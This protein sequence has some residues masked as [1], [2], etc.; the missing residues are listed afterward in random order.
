MEERRHYARL[1]SH[2]QM[3][4]TVLGT[5][6]RAASQTRDAGGGGVCFFTDQK[7][8]RGTMMEIVIEFPERTLTFTGTVVWSGEVL[9]RDEG[10]DCPPFQTGVKF[11]TITPHDLTFVI[12]HCAS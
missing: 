5:G 11:V 1:S 8:E 6:Q 3:H 10:S 2:L 7:F 4:Y 9:V 12:E